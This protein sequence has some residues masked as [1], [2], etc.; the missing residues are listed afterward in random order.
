[1][2]ALGLPLRRLYSAEVWTGFFFV[3]A[4]PSTVSSSVAMTSLAKG[5]VPVAIF[6]ATLSSFIGV[7]LTPLADGLVRLDH[8]R[9]LPL[10]QVIIKV[11]L[12]VL[13]PVA[14]GQV[15][16]RWLQAGRRG[17]AAG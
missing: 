2:L 12:L 4:V 9:S 8:R 17:T 6:N 3:A 11:V 5:N 10:G 13:L 14:V 1:M 7:F 16:R 15:A